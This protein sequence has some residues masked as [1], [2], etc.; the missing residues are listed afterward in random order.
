MT[1]RYWIVSE[2]PSVAARRLCPSRRSVKA[3]PDDPYDLAEEHLVYPCVVH[4]EEQCAVVVE[5]VARNVPAVV[6]FGSL[7]SSMRQRLIDDLDRVATPSAAGAAITDDQAILLRAL[8]TGATLAQAAAEAGLSVRTA[9]R[10]LAD[11]RRALDASTNIE[12][13]ARFRRG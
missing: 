3:L 5:S 7:P 12:A 9:N 10:R 4:T 6:R 13:A 11:A 2:V 8:A 1:R